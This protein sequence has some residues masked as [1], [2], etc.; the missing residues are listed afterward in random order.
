MDH[1]IRI[2]LFKIGILV[3]QIKMS[4][5]DIVYDDL[6]NRYQNEKLE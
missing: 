6:N 5:N 3:N 2:K 4:V 1:T